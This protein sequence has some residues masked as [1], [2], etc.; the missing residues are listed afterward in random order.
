V[1]IAFTAAPTDDARSK[2]MPTMSKFADPVS[3][4]DVGY[5]KAFALLAHDQSQPVVPITG[6]GIAQG[7]EAFIG[8]AP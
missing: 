1:T 4:L 8:F 2:G 7:V 5:F 3:C 6:T